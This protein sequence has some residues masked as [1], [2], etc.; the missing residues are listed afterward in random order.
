MVVFDLDIQG[1]AGLETKAR[2]KEHSLK[3]FNDVLTAVLH[4]Y[5][6]SPSRRRRLEGVSQ[7][8]D[9][10]QAQPVRIGRG[11]SMLRASSRFVKQRLV[12]FPGDRD[13]SIQH[14]LQFPAHAASGVRS[15][16]AALALSLLR[17]ASLTSR[18]LA[19]AL[20]VRERASISSWP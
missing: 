8:V 11:G 12:L 19:M 16:W 3:I 4:Q 5:C 20:N 13:K 17:S 6:D 18:A 1:I 15:S 10:N 14:P 7:Q 9:E 2:C